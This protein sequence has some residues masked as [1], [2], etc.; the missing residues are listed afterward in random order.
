[1]EEDGDEGK[2]EKGKTVR[3]RNKGE[4]EKKKLFFNFYS[5]YNLFFFYNFRHAFAAE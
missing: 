3:L 5:N 2:R 4:H 1:M